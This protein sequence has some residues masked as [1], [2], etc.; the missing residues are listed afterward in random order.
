MVDVLGDVPDLLAPTAV[1]HAERLVA[2]VRRQLVEA[3]FDDAIRTTSRSGARL[4]VPT[5][6]AAW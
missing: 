5:I 3:R 4:A 6:F 1:V 2:A